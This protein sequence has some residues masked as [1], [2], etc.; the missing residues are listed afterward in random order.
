MW[1]EESE[2]LTGVEVV[3]AHDRVEIGDSFSPKADFS[4]Q[5]IES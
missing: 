2:G 3:S 5:A 4:G 1:K